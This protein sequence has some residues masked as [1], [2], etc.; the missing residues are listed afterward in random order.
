[1]VNQLLTQMDGAEGLEGVYVL[2]A[3]RFDALR[4]IQCS[5]NAQDLADLTSLIRLCFVQD[6]WID[7]FSVICQG[8]K[9]EEM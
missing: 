6:V 9:N 5:S 2:A 7:R 8:E 1:M 3:T 4:L